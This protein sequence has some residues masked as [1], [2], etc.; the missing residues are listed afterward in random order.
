MGF[1]MEL[2]TFNGLS[3]F[4]YLS[5]FI[6]I[7]MTST[8][9]S[10]GLLLGPILENSCDLTYCWE[11]YMSA[12]ESLRI[13]DDYP[14]QK[15]RPIPTED[16][17]LRCIAYRTFY[18]CLRNMSRACLGD[19]N[20]HSA[21][22][23]IEK[24]MKQFNCSIAGDVFKLKLTESRT[25]PP[26]CSFL[27]GRQRKTTYKHCSIFGDPHIR[28]FNNLFETCGL[29]GA[30]PLIENKYLTIQVTSEQAG[31]GDGTAISKVTVIIKQH[32]DCSV[33]QY[34]SYQATAN[35]LPATFDDGQTLFGLSDSVSIR[36]LKANSHIEIFIRY[37]DTT[38]VVRLQNRYFSVSL[39][40]PEEIVNETNE[41][42]I[43]PL[44]LCSVNCPRR[45]RVD[46]REVLF[47]GQE[48]VH[49]TAMMA[50][51]TA[52]PACQH[53]GLVDYYLDSCV[54]DL[55]TTGDYNFSLLSQHAYND[56]MSLV[57]ETGSL[58]KNRTV[59]LPSDSGILAS[60]SYYLHF[61]VCIL[62][63]LRHYAVNR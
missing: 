19:L 43:N 13:Q 1:R 4:K 30:W 7:L 49:R 5:F 36:E 8:Y 15:H 59:L 62:W 6:T 53:L 52:L 10:T 45:E 63:F 48:K 12:L 27:G 58:L 2:L 46:I 32:E 25:Q 14:S 16:V 17:A 3:L 44:Q 23:G 41:H 50:V 56:A 54:F 60:S 34:I 51:E 26:V 21:H 28:T 39:R 31:S 29:L 47:P 35:E 40:M 38:I 20:F 18:L 33:D 61:F 57:P 55:I 11:L 42:M 37:I 22:K 24:Q 9:S